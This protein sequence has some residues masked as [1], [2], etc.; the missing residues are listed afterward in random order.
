MNK[1][2]GTLGKWFKRKRDGRRGRGRER[3]QVN[4]KSLPLNPQKERKKRNHSSNHC[5]H[6][7][8]NFNFSVKDEVHDDTR[9]SGNRSRVNNYNSHCQFQCEQC[10]VIDKNLSL[11]SGEAGNLY[12][13]TVSSRNH[14]HTHTK[15]CKSA[16][17]VSVTPPDCTQ[18]SGH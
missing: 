10:T 18:S 7:N 13:Q 5:M 12:R 16:S 9:F 2:G 1:R 17:G 4:T 15:S 3:K 14:T 6:V 11:N 8:N